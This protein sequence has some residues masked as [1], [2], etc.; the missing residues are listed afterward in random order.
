M[1]VYFQVDPTI[2]VPTGHS[3][4]KYFSYKYP[5]VSVLFCFVFFQ[6][7]AL[8]FLFVC[9]VFTEYGQYLLSLTQP[10]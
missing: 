9:F 3:V 5:K 4:K 6:A 7:F 8:G 1:L 10:Y 2:R